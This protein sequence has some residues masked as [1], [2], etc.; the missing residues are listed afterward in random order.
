MISAGS[1]HATPAAGRG[2]GNGGRGQGRN[3]GYGKGGGRGGSGSGGRGRSGESANNEGCGPT[4]DIGGWDVIGNP[5]GD[6]ERAPTVAPHRPLEEM[7]AAASATGARVTVWIR[8]LNG[9]S[10]GDGSWIEPK[11]PPTLVTKEVKLATNLYQLKATGSTTTLLH[12]Y[13]ICAV[14]KRDRIDGKPV[15]SVERKEKENEPREP[16]ELREPTP[17]E[18]TGMERDD[19]L[20]ADGTR[21][22]NETKRQRVVEAVVAL[23]KRAAASPSG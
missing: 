21:V 3:D 19:E 16:R 5:R 17:P 11:S 2:V 20:F 14:R 18:K 7:R 9:M 8:R 22:P 6:P 12:E 10:L 4:V 23:E 13:R 15:D 1:C